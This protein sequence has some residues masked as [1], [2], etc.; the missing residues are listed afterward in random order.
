MRVYL[1]STEF[2]QLT[3]A[4]ISFHHDVDEKDTSGKE[5]VYEYARTNLPKFSIGKI[6]YSKV[7]S[8]GVIII[9]IVISGLGD[10]ETYIPKYS[11][12]ITLHVSGSNE[13]V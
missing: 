4:S 8:D 3:S 11:D 5:Y 10:N 7:F 1:P 12:C 13:L 9:D 2:K 6:D